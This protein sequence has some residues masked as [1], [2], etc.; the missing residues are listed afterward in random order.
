[1][2]STPGKDA[3][4]IVEMK[5]KDLGHSIDLVAKAVSGFQRIDS[6]FERSSAVGKMLSSSITCYRKIT[7]E[8]KSQS[9]WQTSLLSYFK[10]SPQPPQL[11]AHTSLTRLQ[12]LTSGQDPPPA[13][14]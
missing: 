10:K 3:V 13:K 1:M 9:V 4:K 11:S 2:E 14:R 7:C 8:R 6:N 12:P 5:T